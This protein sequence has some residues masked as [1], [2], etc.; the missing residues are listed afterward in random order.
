M[1][2][3][4]KT[5][6]SSVK[7]KNLVKKFPSDKLSEDNIAVNNLDLNVESGELVTLLGPS[8]CG[9][10]TTLR[11]IAGFEFPTS[12]SVFIGDEDISSVSPNKRDIGM[13]FQSYALFPHLTVYDNIA[14]GL[15]IKKLSQ[16]EIKMKVKAVLEIMQLH[17]LAD[18]SPSQLS[19]GQQQR[20]ALARAVVTEPKVLLFDEPLSNLDAKLREY[21][22]EE[23]RNIQKRLGI[24]SLYVTHDQ[25]EAMAIS[26]KV[27]IM[28][29]GELQQVDT[30]Y[31][32]YISPA[33]H[34]VADFM[35]KANFVSSVIK[36]INQSEIEIELLGRNITINNHGNKQFKPDE[37]VDCVIRPEFWK[38]DPNGEFNGVVEKV[39]YFGNNVEYTIKI[40]EEELI[41]T[42][43]DHVANGVRSVGENINLHLEKGN[44]SLLK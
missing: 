29:D 4:L 28:N 19:G 32:I 42:D 10:T 39:I 9:K 41:F 43:T 36:D 1:V 40:N 37:Q 3:G 38:I 5:Q 13:V 25:T 17:A 21:M 31:N 18:R 12:G 7:L 22:R 8:G 6:T 2:K 33:N 20:V 34:F 14:Y 24:T 16:E 15:K 11:M 26:D 23:L 35:G 44:L 30:P 27:V